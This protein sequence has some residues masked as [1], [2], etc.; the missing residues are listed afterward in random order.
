MKKSLMFKLAHIVARSIVA[1]VGDYQIAFSLA[2]KDIWGT[3]KNTEKQFDEETVVAGLENILHDAQI[4]E[5]QAKKGYTF[6]VPN[7]VIMKSFDG[8]HGDLRASFIFNGTYE[9]KVV[10]ETEKAEQINFV[11]KSGDI[12]VWCPKSVLAA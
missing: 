5:G 6:G 8:A 7:W 12:K 3:V 4:K 10:R 11:T 2:L 1:E 9:I